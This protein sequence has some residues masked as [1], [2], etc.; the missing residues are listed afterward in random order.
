MQDVFQSLSLSLYFC[1]SVWVQHFQHASSVAVVNPESFVWFSQ[2][3]R[4]CCCCWSCWLAICFCGIL[5]ALTAAPSPASYPSL[6]LS[7][8]FSLPS[9]FTFLTETCP[10]VYGT[11]HRKPL[12]A[13]CPYLYFSLSTFAYRPPSLPFT[14]PP[15][16]KSE[17]SV[18]TFEM[19][20]LTNRMRKLAP[21]SASVT[22]LGVWDGVGVGVDSPR[23]GAHHGYD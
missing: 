5:H 8:S 23:L 15:S 1:F 6:S 12:A 11:T 9:P 19:I 17:L 3:L 18:K 2:S 10:K 16:N 22:Q 4:R 21:A 13:G 20:S 14:T 7:L